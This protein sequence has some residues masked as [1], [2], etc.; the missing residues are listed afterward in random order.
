MVHD[1]KHPVDLFVNTRYPE[2]PEDARHIL[3]DVLLR[4]ELKKGELLF[5]EGDIAKYIIAIEKG[6]M[7]QFYY[8]NK[9]DL[10]EHFSYEGC[11]LVCL[12][13][14]LK[15][16]PTRLMAEALEPCVVYALPHEALNRLMDEHKQIAIYYRKMLE[17]SLIM[18]QIK[19]DL[20]RYETARERYLHLL[21]AQPEVIRR[22][23]LSYIASYLM[24]TPE[25]LS[26]V[27]ASVVLSQKS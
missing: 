21:K 26:R 3:G 20:W 7:R 4:M 12:E 10:T 23:P 11:T 6:M 14:F 18:S 25:T 16:E 9:K 22:A 15:N 19:A 17:Y 1:A 5:K 27:R 8:K 13:S 24:M 2:M